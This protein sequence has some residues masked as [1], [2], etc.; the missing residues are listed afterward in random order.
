M[1]QLNNFYFSSYNTLNIS[2]Y[3]RVLWYHK[4]LHKKFISKHCRCNLPDFIYKEM[5]E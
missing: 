4:I 1:L 5:F 2:R 3:I